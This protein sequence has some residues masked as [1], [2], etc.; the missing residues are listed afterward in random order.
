[1]ELGTNE[2]ALPLAEIEQALL[3]RAIPK[4]YSKVVIYLRLQP[5]AAQEVRLK[6]EYHD[7]SRPDLTTDDVPIIPSNERYSRVRAMLSEKS[8][9]L[10]LFCPIAKLVGNFQ[11]G[12]LTSLELVSVEEKFA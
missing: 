8:G 4:S 7:T 11:D 5:T 1:M 6:I 9:K 10:K 3:S 2:I 12:K